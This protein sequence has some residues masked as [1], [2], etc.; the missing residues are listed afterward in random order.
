MAK[1]NLSM[2]MTVTATLAPFVLCESAQVHRGLIPENESERLKVRRS[3]VFFAHPDRDVT[4]TCMDGSDKYPPVNSAQYLHD[5]FLSTYSH[6]H[7][8]ARV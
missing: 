1:E 8:T 5:K 6:I 7:P 2:Q 3:M 4:V